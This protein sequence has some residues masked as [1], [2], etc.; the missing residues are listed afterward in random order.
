MSGPL[1]AGLNLCIGGKQQAL[2]GIN[3]FGFEVRSH[4]TRRMHPKLCMFEC[5]TTFE[6]HLHCAERANRV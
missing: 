2:K 1:V 5:H 3:W 6:G 4:V